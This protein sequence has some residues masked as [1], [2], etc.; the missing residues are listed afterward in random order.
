MN[1]LAARLPFLPKV[2]VRLHRAYCPATM[3][4]VLSGLS[5]WSSP[6]ILTKCTILFSRAHAQSPIC[7]GRSGVQTNNFFACQPAAAESA[8][9]FPGDICYSN[10][11]CAP[12]PSEKSGITPFVWNGCTDPTYTSSA[13]FAACYNGEL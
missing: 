10:G 7:Y 11:L 2:N 8:C 4:A 9:C 6:R 5:M 13:C 3:T 1:S 12:G